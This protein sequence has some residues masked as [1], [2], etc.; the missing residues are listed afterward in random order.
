MALLLALDDTDGPGGGCTTHVA[1]QI[2][3]TLGPHAMADLPRLVRLFPSNPWKTR[4]NAAVVLPLEED[5]DPDEVLDQAFEVVC[6]H[7][8]VAEGKG[9]GLALFESPPEARWYRQGVRRPVDFEEATTALAEQGAR[10]QS[11]GTG[12]G[13]IG[14]LCAAAW[15]P[16]DQAT[17]EH[18][19]YRHPDRWG[20][21]RDVDSD[22]VAAVAAGHPE[23]FD[24]L[25]PVDGHLAMVPATPCPVLY[26]LRAI[27]PDRL[28]EAV[29]A[30]GSEPVLGRQL[31]VSNQAS[32]DHVRDACLAPLT[33]T[34]APQ[35]LTGGHVRLAGQTEEGDRRV[36]MAFEPT[37]QLRQAVLGVEPG[38]R[39]LPVGHLEDGQINLEKLLHVPARRR[40]RQRCPAC[41]RAMS[42]TGAR[43][44]VRCKRCGHR[45]PKR[46]E[47]PE[48]T[49]Y[50]A[51]VSARRHLARPLALGLSP[52]L[53]AAR[54]QLVG[55]TAAQRPAA[56][57]ST[58]P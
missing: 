5:L 23:T 38:D 54:R 47:Q 26:G 28:T 25:D 7:A 18:I 16:G 2:H 35:A 3:R 51:D 33:V 52:R 44:G 55:G 45:A 57:P 4:G 21:D 14:C 49:W 20:T 50:E 39:I 1:W 9:A 41:D 29:S 8:R 13:L 46:Y 40:R 58:G 53:E 15:R 56:L 43:G 34:Q 32:D 22:A 10:T 19:A 11:L 37:G 42:S 48:P 30:I 31:F 27:R 17:Y 12:R 24:T 36:C 6:R